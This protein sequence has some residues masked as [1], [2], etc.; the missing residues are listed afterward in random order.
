MDNSAVLI[1]A[2]AANSEADHSVAAVSASIRLLALGFGTNQDPIS[3][4]VSNHGEAK[5]GPN[6]G[7]TGEFG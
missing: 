3:G 7:L 4:A 1:G 6:Y 2:A 5:T